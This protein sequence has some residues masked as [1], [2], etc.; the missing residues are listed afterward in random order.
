MP[1]LHLDSTAATV[2]WLAHQKARLITYKEFSIQLQEC[3]HVLDWRITS[4]ANCLT[5]LPLQSCYSFLNVFMVVLLHTFLIWS[6]NIL[7]L[8]H[9]GHPTAICWLFLKRGWKVVS[10]SL[11]T[12]GLNYGSL[13]LTTHLQLIHL[14]LFKSI[15]K[16]ICSTGPFL[17]PFNFHT[18]CYLYPFIFILFSYLFL[19]YFILFHFLLLI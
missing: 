13:S 3:W 1:L 17:K 11:V 6:L 19:I 9:L 12:M 18:W 2:F 7:L 10:Q 4:Q 14:V 5:E 16:S 15:S 8:D